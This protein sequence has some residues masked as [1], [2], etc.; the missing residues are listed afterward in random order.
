[1]NA[2]SLTCGVVGALAALGAWT[3]SAA[4]HGIVYT[5]SGVGDGV[6]GT[7][8][9]PFVPFDNIPFRIYA[10]SLAPVAAIDV[11]GVANFVIL[12]GAQIQKVGESTFKPI[13]VTGVPFFAAGEGSNDGSA[14]FGNLQSGIPVADGIFEGPGLSGYDGVSPLAPI[15]VIFDTLPG[16]KLTDGTE[17]QFTAIDRG[18]FSAVF[19][20]EPGT[21]A[22]MLLG[23]G[24]AGGALRRRR[25][26]APV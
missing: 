2:K 22:M 18:T 13:D 23:L 8:A 5:L 16:L 12:S 21:W 1:M 9:G 11:P 3:T 15:P 26:G 24:L 17:V 20:P 6:S 7:G 19:V 25:A 4:A 10:E 14:A